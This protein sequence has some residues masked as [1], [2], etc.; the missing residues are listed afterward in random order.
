VFDTST[1][2]PFFSAPEVAEAPNILLHRSIHGVSGL[3]DLDEI[4][5]F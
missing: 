2:P 1:A 5:G 4:V 3:E